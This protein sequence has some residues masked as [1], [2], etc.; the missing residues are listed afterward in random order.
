MKAYVGDKITTPSVTVRYNYGENDTITNPDWDTK[1]IE[2][3]VKKGAGEYKIT[4]TVDINGKSYDVSFNL[5]IEEYNYLAD[6]NYSFE[7]KDDGKWKINCD[8]KQNG[9]KK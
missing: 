3:A 4:G 9:P 6:K 1:A 7:N 8:N 2:E 5:K